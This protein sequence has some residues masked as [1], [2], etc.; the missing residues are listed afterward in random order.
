MYQSQNDNKIQ[1]NSSQINPE[2]NSD[3]Y[4]QQ[5]Q[6]VTVMSWFFP[7]DVLAP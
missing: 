5:T 1:H 4:Y 3:L 7:P 6:N 2:S